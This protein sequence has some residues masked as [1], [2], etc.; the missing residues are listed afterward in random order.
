MQLIMIQRLV[1]MNVFWR[2]QNTKC[3]SNTFSD[4]YKRKGTFL[5]ISNKL[6]TK[7]GNNAFFF[8]PG[9][10]KVSVLK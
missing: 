3:R 7:V 4:Q 5:C 10:A 9:W 2:C 1:L 6:N 8:S